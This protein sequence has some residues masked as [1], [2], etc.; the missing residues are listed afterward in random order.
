VHAH[1]G[2]EFC[3]NDIIKGY[4]VDRDRNLEVTK[5]ELENIAL[6][7]TRGIHTRDRY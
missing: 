2:E 1:T 6:Q 5:D 7:S 3:S 4:Q